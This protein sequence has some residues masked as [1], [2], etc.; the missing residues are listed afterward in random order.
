MKSVRI[1]RYK[2]YAKGAR[3]SAVTVPAVFLE[4]E[5]LAQGDA[6]DL[7]RVGRLLIVAPSG[8]SVD[9]ELKKAAS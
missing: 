3:G 2:L 7:A 1:G 9:A 5:G 4:D 6:V 8:V